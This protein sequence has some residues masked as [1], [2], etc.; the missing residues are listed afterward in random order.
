MKT[1][2]ENKWLNMVDKSNYAYNVTH[3]AYVKKIK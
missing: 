2:D 1:N 3:S